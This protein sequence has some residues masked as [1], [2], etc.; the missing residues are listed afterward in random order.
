MNVNNT[1]QFISTKFIH[2]KIYMTMLF[3]WLLHRHCSYNELWTLQLS[4][5]CDIS[6]S[7]VRSQEVAAFH[8]LFHYRCCHAYWQTLLHSPRLNQSRLKHTKAH[9]DVFM[10][11]RDR[12]TRGQI[13][14][15]MMYW[16]PRICNETQFIVTCKDVKCI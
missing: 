11:V 10:W 14:W 13:F 3:W 12:R 16:F 1:N 7:L 9:M 4:C 2:V 5:N 6:L 15:W 8:R